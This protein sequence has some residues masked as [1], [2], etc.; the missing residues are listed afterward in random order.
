MMIPTEV[1]E[2]SILLLLLLVALSIIVWRVTLDSEYQGQQTESYR[3]Q[4]NIGLLRRVRWSLLWVGGIGLIV[5]GPLGIW[6]IRDGAV[7]V[8]RLLLLYWICGLI[9][10]VSLLHWIWNPPQPKAGG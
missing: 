5:T 9:W 8:D 10:M 7:H 4:T 2:G 6:L 1:Y 3:H